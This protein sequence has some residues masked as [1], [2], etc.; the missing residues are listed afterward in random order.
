MSAWFCFNFEQLSHRKSILSGASLTE[1]LLLSLSG[2][3]QLL[4]YGGIILVYHIY[5][6]SV[7][8]NDKL[9]VEL[10]KDDHYIKSDS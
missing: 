6:G 2:Q 8:W 1:V 3:I 7:F 5:S 9:L 4:A 10:L